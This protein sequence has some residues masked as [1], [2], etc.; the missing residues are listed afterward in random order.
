MSGRWYWALIAATLAVY[1][2]IV[3][4]SLPFVQAEAG[5]QVPFDMRPFG[6]GPEEARAFLAALSDAGREQYLGVQHLL[7]TLYPAMLAAVLA[8]ALWRLTRGVWQAL[9][10]PVPL[11]ASAF[12]YLESI[13]VRGLLSSNPTAV[14]DEAIA[15]A[16]FATLAKSA[17]T[18]LA[19]AALLAALALR[20]W[21]RR[22]RP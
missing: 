16:S 7:D 20:V 21:Q 1:G 10:V 6:Y 19:V 11:V 18:T 2:A 4:W 17:L 12:D 22:S 14:S 15:A 5:G 3:M 9:L 13:R 8:I